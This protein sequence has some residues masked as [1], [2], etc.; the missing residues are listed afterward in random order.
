MKHHYSLGNL[1][2]T[3][4]HHNHEVLQLTLFVYARNEPEHPSCLLY[5]IHTH[6]L[7]TYT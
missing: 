5:A 2:A 7:H 6:K 3:I 1:S 4:A